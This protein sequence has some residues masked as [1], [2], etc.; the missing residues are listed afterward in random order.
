MCVSTGVCRGNFHLA[1]TSPPYLG[2]GTG[3]AELAT[4]GSRF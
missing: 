4:E 1:F 2:T 3:A